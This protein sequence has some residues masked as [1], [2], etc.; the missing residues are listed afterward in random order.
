MVVDEFAEIPDAVA[1]YPQSPKAFLLRY[2]LTPNKTFV[3]L[4]IRRFLSISSPLLALMRPLHS[5]AELPVGTAVVGEATVSSGMVGVGCGVSV[6]VPVGGT[7]VAV[8]MAVCVRATIVFSTTTAEACTCAGS[9]VGT[10]FTPHELNNDAKIVIM[11]NKSFGFMDFFLM[12]PSGA[13]TEHTRPPFLLSPFSVSRMCDKSIIK[14][15]NQM[16]PDHDYG[17]G[18]Y[19]S[20]KSVN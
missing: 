1:Q 5:P 14:N 6:G 7:G 4:L 12:L 20:F 17:E 19:C 10:A 3:L 16:D 11:A 8:G 2:M 15:T 9:I 18:V 13:A